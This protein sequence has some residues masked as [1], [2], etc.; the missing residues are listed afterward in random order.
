M[1]SKQNSAAVVLLVLLVAAGYG[2]F[3][4]GREGAVSPGP[5]AHFSFSDSA[6]LV[7]Q[8]SLGTA[9][10]LVRLSTTA[11]ERP[12]AEDALRLADQEMDLAFAAAV[13]QAANHPRPL[14]A[15]AQ[16]I[17]ARLQQAQTT[18]VADQAQVAELTTALSKA[19]AATADA[20]NDQLNL[21]KA[22][23]ALDQDEADDAKQDLM[24]AGGD[25]QGRMEAMIQQHDAASQSSDSTR[26]TV[27]A[28]VEV[29]GL[30]HR[31]QS[32]SAL[33]Q[34][35]LQLGQ[36][37]A[38]AESLAVVFAKRHDLMKARAIARR[39]D[40]LRADLSHD[41]S[42]ALLAMTQ[43]RARNEKAQ[44]AL[45]QRVDNQRQLADVYTRWIG[46]VD[47][48]ERAVIN[49]ALRGFAVILIIILIGLFF[50]KW[51]EHVLGTMPMDRR[52]MQTLFMVSRV[53]LEIVGVL[54]ILLVIFGR[55]DNLGTFLGL[56]GAGL[57]VALKDFII[58][59][60]GWFVLM[61]KNGLR[62]GDLVEINGVTGEVV[63]LGMFHTMLLE[64]GS[65]SDSGHPTGRRVTFMNSFAIEGHYFNFS[66]SGQW[67]WDE[68]RIVVPAGHDP[69][70]IVDAIQKQAEEATAD[71]ARE[72]EQEWKGARRSPQ[73]SALT[74]APAVNIKPIIG[75]VEITVRYITQVGE[76]S[77]LRAKLYHTAVDLLGGTHAALPS[78]V[79]ATQALA[80]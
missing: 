68:I 29:S 38:A 39:R 20:L 67:L 54:F 71:S 24:R 48:Q 18:L 63:E 4:T 15:E 33:R 40:G 66:T 35:E 10:R 49:R 43:R 47:V 27:T 78:P 23:V 70:P 46:V 56:A 55:P 37:K 51:I 28:P 21:A 3:Q 8:V 52:Q 12:L 42:A 22:Q 79:A 80:T 64:T 60:F 9:L 14:S 44:A 72:A 53:S 11:D 31:A 65:W 25:P 5:I 59:F 17:D 61:G 1:R 16:A 73:L 26:V 74:A 62:I 41:S 45:D 6:F 69:Y 34:K 76:R 75:G 30:I 19:N 32:W 7:D 57:T 50:E 36:A 77:Q 58:G 2:V 13:R